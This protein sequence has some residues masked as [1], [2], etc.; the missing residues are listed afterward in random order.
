[1]AGGEPGLSR[2]ARIRLL[3]DM[4]GELE[5]LRNRIPESVADGTLEE[6]LAEVSH[7]VPSATPLVAGVY[8]SLYTSLATEAGMLAQLAAAMRVRMLKTG[9]P[10]ISGVDYIRRRLDEFLERLNAYVASLA[11]EQPGRR[12]YH[13]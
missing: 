4:I 9:T 6:A 10:Y 5:V 2:E 13:L 8:R 11:A 7:Y 3:R 1:M 12:L